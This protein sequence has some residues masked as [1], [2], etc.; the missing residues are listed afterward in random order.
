VVGISA[1]SRDRAPTVNP[2]AHEPV[3]ISIDTTSLPLSIESAAF[4]VSYTIENTSCLKPMAISGAIAPP[5]EP[6]TITATQSAK[7]VFTA[8]I[9]LDH[10]MDT[11]LDGRGVC[12]WRVSAAEFTLSSGD[13]KLVAGIGPREI[14][15]EGSETDYF[16]TWSLTSAPTDRPQA[17]FSDPSVVRRSTKE[18]IYA[19]TVTARK[20]D[21]A[22]SETSHP[23]IAC[24]PSPT[25]AYD[26]TVAVSEAP[27]PFDS[28]KAQAFYQVD[29]PSCAPTMRASGVVDVPH[30]ALP[31]SLVEH[32]DGRYRTRFALDPFVDEDYFGQGICHWSFSS[33][34]ITAVKGNVSYLATYT[35][36]DL[37]SST[38]A[39]NYFA[40]GTFGSSSRPLKIAGIIDTG[41]FGANARIFTIDINADKAKRES[42]DSQRSTSNQ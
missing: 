9:N 27:G 31:L 1:C 32:S 13:R 42:L 17:G 23:K 16:S 18:P 39:R 30:A 29:N 10:F 40:R 35:S 26:A 25:K 24:N 38:E 33:L 19:V 8:T 11:D 3:V 22:C 34:S 6:L 36:R 12:H 21:A 7:G 14:M 5:F 37:T 41:V 4:T 20:A 15:N 28:I 2:N